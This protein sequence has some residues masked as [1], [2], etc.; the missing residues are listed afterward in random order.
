MPDSRFILGFQL[1]P[2]NPSPVPLRLVKAPAALSPRERAVLITFAEGLVIGH[3]VGF[4]DTQMLFSQF[5][6][7]LHSV[8]GKTQE[9]QVDVGCQ[10]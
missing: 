2:T 1:F 7:Q 4:L 10:T 5:E 8:A 9:N 3:R 6:E